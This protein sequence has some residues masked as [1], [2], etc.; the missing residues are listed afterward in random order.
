[1]NGVVGGGEEDKLETTELG[2]MSSGL[3]ELLCG[4]G[5]ILGFEGRCLDEI[6]DSL[7]NEILWVNAGEVKLD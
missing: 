3:G 4:T 1:M 6:L 5:R 2:K 7:S